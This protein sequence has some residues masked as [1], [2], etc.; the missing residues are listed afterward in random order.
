MCHTSAFSL[1]AS[2]L[3][4]PRNVTRS[5]EEIVEIK[6][7][8]KAVER[9]NIVWYNK[10]EQKLVEYLPQFVS[11]TLAKGLEQEVEN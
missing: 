2:L 3:K 8:C 10:G 7:S 9:K 6:Q 4:P 11:E 1:H 5:P